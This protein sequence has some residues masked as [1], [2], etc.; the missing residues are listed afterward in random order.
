LNPEVPV[1]HPQDDDLQLFVLG[2][3]SAAEVAALERHVFDCVECIERLGTTARVVDKILNLLLDNA[4]ADKQA[5]PRFH[6]SDAVFLRSLSPAMPDRW[7]VQIVD[8][9]K[10]GLGLLVPTLLSPGCVVQVQSG[11]T[12]ALCEVRHCREIGEHLFYA[13]IKLQDVVALRP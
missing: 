1:R 13:D 12:L 7:P 8:V 11:A 4:A 9:S 3:L 10:N 6:I 5:E 2:R